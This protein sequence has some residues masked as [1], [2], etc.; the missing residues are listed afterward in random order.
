RYPLIR[1]LSTG[2]LPLSFRDILG[3]LFFD[4]GTA[5]NDP[6]YYRAT[7]RDDNGNVVTQDLLMGTGFGAR[8][9]F[10]FFLL[11]LDVAWAYNIQS[12]SAPHYYISI[13]EDF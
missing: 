10:L 3:T 9:Y 2:L 12:F 8:I 7:N 11:K 6:K 5:W 4:V 13:G 1:T